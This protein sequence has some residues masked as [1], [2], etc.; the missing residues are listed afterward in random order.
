[1]PAHRKRPSPPAR[2]VE[3]LATE[4]RRLLDDGRRLT[5]DEFEAAWDAAWLLMVA[6]RAWPHATT[7]RRGWRVAMLEAMKPEARACFL[8][9]PSGFCKWVG[10]LA[11]ALDG[12]MF[13]GEE[14]VV[15]ELV[16]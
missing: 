6:E 8:D 2:M 5:I 15:G 14:I 9:Q 4:K 12:S 3:L 10:A 7:E 1:M 11:D 13:A 16:A